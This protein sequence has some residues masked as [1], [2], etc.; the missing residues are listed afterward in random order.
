MLNVGARSR[1]ALVSSALVMRDLASKSQLLSIYSERGRDAVIEMA[2]QAAKTGSSLDAVSGMKDAFGDV[3]N[4]AENMMNLSVAMGNEFTKSLGTA[5]ELFILN[6]Q[7]P[8]GRLEIQK[9]IIKAMDR[10]FK[11]NNEGEVI[12]INIIVCVPLFSLAKL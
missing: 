10:E 8:E 5:H 9:R 11:L 4:I 7:G 6:K 1:K 2:V 3:D 12:N